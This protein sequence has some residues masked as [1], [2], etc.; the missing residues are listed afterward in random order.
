VDRSKLEYQEQLAAFV[1][2]AKADIARVIAS[3]G[4]AYLY[5]ALH[6]EVDA[7]FGT[8]NEPVGL[9]LIELASWGANGWEVVGVVP[10][11][12]SGQ[13][14]YLAKSRMTMRDWGGVKTEHRSTT[15]G[16]VMGV[17]LLMKLAVTAESASSLEAV[18]EQALESNFESTFEELLEE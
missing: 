3:G 6:V 4:T 8:A 5:S 10:R 14:S 9:P 13:E 18:I 15:S 17:Y 16:N 2:E 12:Y 11:T 1:R 7:Q